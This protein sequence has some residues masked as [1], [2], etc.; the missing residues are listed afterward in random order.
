[1]FYVSISSDFPKCIK[2][3]PSQI[4]V[5]YGKSCEKTIV[6]NPS[7]ALIYVGVPGVHKILIP[8]LPKDQNAQMSFYVLQ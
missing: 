3:P 6:L 5:F 4:P 8:K 1:M 7:K 2:I